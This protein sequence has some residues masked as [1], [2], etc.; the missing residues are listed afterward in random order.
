MDQ[1]ERRN[2]GQ[3]VR[4]ASPEFGLALDSLAVGEVEPGSAGQTGRWLAESHVQA[5]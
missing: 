3:P 5:K 1:A 4:P 2:I